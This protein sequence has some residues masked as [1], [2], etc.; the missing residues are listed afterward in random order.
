MLVTPGTSCNTS[1]GLILY[2]SCDLF[3]IFQFLLLEC[4]HFA[5]Q[6]Y[7]EGSII[8]IIFWLLFGWL[9]VCSWS[10]AGSREQFFQSVF[11]SSC[12]VFIDAF[13]SKLNNPP[14]L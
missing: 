9:F 13:H 7:Y 8:D 1:C 12:F 2:G 10:K 14:P 11:S 3:L 5:F 4:F 6:C